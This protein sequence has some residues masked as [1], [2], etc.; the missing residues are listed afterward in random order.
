MEIDDEDTSPKS[1][2]RRRINVRFCRVYNLA[3][4]LKSL[5]PRCGKP[6]ELP[7]GEATPVAVRPSHMQRNLIWNT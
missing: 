7:A 4:N 2:N 6:G 3:Q 5:Q 1:P